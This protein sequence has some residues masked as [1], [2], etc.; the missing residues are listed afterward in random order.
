MWGLRET[1]P[2][3][4]QFSKANN[5]IQY[6]ILNNNKKMVKKQPVQCLHDNSELP[7]FVEDV[8]GTD[9]MT[10]YLCVTGGEKLAKFM[11]KQSIG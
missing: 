9:H 5:N 7:V 3:Y 10:I 1:V 4:A 8:N 11:K 2:G 6:P